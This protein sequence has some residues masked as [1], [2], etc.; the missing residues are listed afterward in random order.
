MLQSHGTPDS[1]GKLAT[2]ASAEVYAWETGRVVKLFR[3]DF[4][5]EA[6]EVELR[7]A[8]IAHGLGMPTPS[9]EGLVELGGRTGIVFERCDGPTLYELIQ[10]RT[11]PLVELAHGFFELQQVIHRCQSPALQ[12]LHAKLARRIAYARDVPES[13]KNEAIGIVHA[14][15]VGNAVCHGDFHPINVIVA[16]GGPVVIDWL[17]AGRGDPA[18]DVTRTLLYL[19]YSRPRQIDLGARAAFLNAYLDRCREAW[20]GRMEQLQRWQFPVAVA[21]LSEAVE[22]SERAGLMKLVERTDSL[23]R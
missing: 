7:H 21:R 2:G 12:P 14:A 20:A 6:I 23:W 18:I 16:A 22:D 3:R 4:P 11:R 5:R 8:R 15:P 17:D 1:L 19:K 10:A 9:V 13:L